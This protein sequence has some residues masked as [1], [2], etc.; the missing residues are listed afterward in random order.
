M[1]RHCAGKVFRVL[2][3]VVAI[4]GGAAW[5]DTDRIFADSFGAVC[6]NNAVEFPET[7]DGNCPVCAEPFAG[8]T[9]SGSE[10]TC[11]VV[12]HI[13]IQ[14]CQPGDNVCPFV[15]GSGG[16]QCNAQSD[17]ECVGTAWKPLLFTMVNT[18]GQA[19]VAVNIYGIQPGGSYDITTCAPTPALAG[20]G[21][22]N[23]TTITDNLGAS[24]AV[25][26]DDCSDPWSLPLLAGW[27]CNNSQGL[28]RMSC[29][30]PSPTG[31]RVS[32]A[33]VYRLT[34]SVCP[35]GADGGLA[36]LYIW[37]NASTTPN[38]G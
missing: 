4:T 24:Y 19:C 33:G 14:T 23:I 30:S 25:G 16:S 22:T 31:F 35:L 29:A 37:Y 12:C 1:R 21:D 20:A 9:S 8:F 18:S 32:S 26:N 11:D 2:G 5:A 28:A 13:P 34:V 38:P 3:C 7:C 15:A 36:P 10:A 17:A 6:G 27:T